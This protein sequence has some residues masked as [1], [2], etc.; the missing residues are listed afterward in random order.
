VDLKTA[1][2]RGYICGEHYPAIDNRGDV[3]PALI[4]LID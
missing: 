1:L 2:H 4:E 3:N